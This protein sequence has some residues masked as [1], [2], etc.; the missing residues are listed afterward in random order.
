MQAITVKRVF[1]VIIAL[2]SMSVL[3]G[4]SGL[5]K[6]PADRSGYLYYP[7]ALV[8]ADQAL[9]EARTAGKD[10][11]CPAEYNAL[12]AQVDQAYEDYMICRTQEAIDTANDAIPKIKALCPARPSAVVKPEPKPEPKPRIVETMIVLE[13]VHFGLDKSSLTKEAQTILRRNIQIMK[14][15]P[16]MKVIIQGHTSAIA[17]VEYNQKLSERR[18]ASVKAFLVKEGG[19]SQDRLST[20]G[21]GETQLE[22]PEPNERD[23]ESPAAK[24]N[25]S[26]IFK[27]TVR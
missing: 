5:V 6:R 10:K 25:R 24:I 23:V 3:A 13:D 22:R 19:I 7:A 14:E 1:M 15:N 26:V 8:Q 17:T 27:I 21:Y 2:F 18:A 20:I 4:C 11:Q 9:A 16:N 12:K